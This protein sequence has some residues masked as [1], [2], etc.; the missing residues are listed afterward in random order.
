MNNFYLSVFFVSICVVCVFWFLFSSWFNNDRLNNNNHHHLS[1]LFSI[2]LYI[3]KYLNLPKWFI[4]L[5]KRCRGYRS[6]SSLSK[7]TKK[8]PHDWIITHTH[9]ELMHADMTTNKQTKKKHNL[10]L[11]PD[12]FLFFYFF[13]III[14]IIGV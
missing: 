8:K 5:F 11:L 12:W 13:I 10:L 9:T 6:L 14:I 4:F 1:L 2:S 7:M 3:S